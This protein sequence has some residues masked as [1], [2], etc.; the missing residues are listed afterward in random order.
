MTAILSRPQCVKQTAGLN[1]SFFKSSKLMKKNI[2]I[3]KL[4]TNINL[5]DQR[6]FGLMRPIS[7]TPLRNN[8]LI[9]A[10]QISKSVETSRHTMH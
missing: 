8:D 2:K 4:C 5:Q 3:K 1:H 10:R 9:L 6:Q 7:I